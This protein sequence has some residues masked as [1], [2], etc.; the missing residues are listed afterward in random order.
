[1]GYEEFQKIWIRQMAGGGKLKNQKKEK[2]IINAVG[3]F[4]N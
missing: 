4:Q 3:K 1:L 2:I